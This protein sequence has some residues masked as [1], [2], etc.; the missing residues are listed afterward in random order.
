M[1][2][3]KTRNEEMLEKILLVRTIRGKLNN[4]FKRMFKEEKAMF[5]KALNM[6]EDELSL[7]IQKQNNNI[8]LMLEDGIDPKNKKVVVPIDENKPSFPELAEIGLTNSIQNKKRIL[9]NIEFNLGNYLQ[10]LPS[11]EAKMVLEVLK[12]YTELL[13]IEAARIANN[14]KHN[15]DIYENKQKDEYV[16]LSYQE[17]FNSLYD[18][19]KSS[20]K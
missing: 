6:Y 10:Q 8:D 2:N 1:E 7:E 12:R 17:R 14:E 16:P 18:T 11:N 13:Q 19:F 15:S 20:K 4:E 3:N 9:K 5:L